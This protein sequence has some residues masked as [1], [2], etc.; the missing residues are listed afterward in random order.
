MP[1]IPWTLVLRIGAVL[2][3]LLVFWW[4]FL[5]NVQRL[6][7]FPI[8]DP[9]RERKPPEDA[10]VV[11]L[12]GKGGETEAWYLPPT[13]GDTKRPVPILIFAHGNATLIDEIAAQFDP[14][15]KWGVGILLVE[16]PGYGRSGGRPSQKAIGETMTA[17]FD[18]A[19]AQPSIDPKRIIGYGRSLGGGAICQLSLDRDLAALILESTFTST[20]PFAG[21]YGAPGFLILDPFD[22]L[23]VVK[24][25]SQPILLFHGEKDEVIP[26]EHGVQ[27]AR[28]AGV[29]LRVHGGGHNDT[30]RPWETILKFLVENR[31]LE[32]PIPHL[33]ARAPLSGA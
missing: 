2:L 16:Y 4:G 3:V 21:R 28:A 22:N 30:P 1:A 18:W 24:K 11:W 25:Q 20:R 5:F 8:P 32:S 19:L 12:P 13:G 7:L 6:V 26:L 29:S 17:A 23:D 14:P 10:T 33:G 27:L 9:L 31:L 15:R